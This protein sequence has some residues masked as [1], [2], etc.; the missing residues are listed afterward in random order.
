[1]ISPKPS[2]AATSKRLLLPLV[3]SIPIDDDDDNDDNDDNDD[4]DDDDDDD[5]ESWF[6]DDS[7]R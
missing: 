6:D 5:D 2:F 1:M 4:S 7:T 3:R